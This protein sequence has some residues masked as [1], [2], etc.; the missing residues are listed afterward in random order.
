MVV[1]LYR[2]NPVSMLPPRDK[3]KAKEN[4]AKDTGK[5]DK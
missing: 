1:A 2:G 4:A 3:D 5:Q